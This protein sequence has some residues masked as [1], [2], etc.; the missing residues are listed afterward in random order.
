MRVE[1]IGDCTLY[2]A[3]CREVLP[4]LGKVDRIISDPPYGVSDG[5]GSG[6]RKNR[7]SK[8]AYNC[9]SDTEQNCIDVII[10]SVSAALN[11]AK[12][13]A[14]TTGFRMMHHY[15]KPAHVGSFQYP[16]STVMS[17]WGP[18]LWQPIFYYGKDPY[19]GHLRPDSFKNC[20]DVDRD[21][22]H[23][24]PKPLATWT[25]LVAR[26]SLRNDV[27]LDLFTGSGTT[28]VACVNLVRKFIGIEL[29]PDY[30]DIACKRIAEAYKQPRLFDE[31]T[32]KPKQDS[33]I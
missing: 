31:P 4:T 14:I 10:P 28:G 2:L 6:L 19:Q 5:V 29:D 11:L 16:A 17:C 15:P 18:C 33:F 24:C 26:T 21:T 23:P 13:G 8:T 27:V 3:D 30:F 9:F 32:P 22:N 20:N 1:Q 12:S 7:K 25:K